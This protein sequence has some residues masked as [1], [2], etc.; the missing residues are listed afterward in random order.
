MVPSGPLYAAAPAGVSS[1][2]AELRRLRK[3]ISMAEA[4][5]AIVVV[6]IAAVLLLVARG[7]ERM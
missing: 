4:S 5:V 2:C 1:I 7:L 3:G 6:A